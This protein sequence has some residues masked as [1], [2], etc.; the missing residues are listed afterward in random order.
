MLS[1]AFAFM[2]T[3][4]LI[5][6]AE[7]AVKVTDGACVSGTLC[8]I[9]VTPEAVVVLPAASLAL[10]VTEY[11]PSATVVVFQ[12]NCKVVRWS[13]VPRLLPFKSELHSGDSD[14]IIGCGVDV[15]DS[16]DQSRCRGC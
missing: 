7:G 13:S 9:T 5:I 3:V 14:I 10:A 4:P 15:D 6:P 8:T 11:C 12:E 16:I 2:L 1:E